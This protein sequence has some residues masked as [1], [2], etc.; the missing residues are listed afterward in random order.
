[1]ALAAS[2]S[3]TGVSLD[4]SANVG[5]FIILSITSVLLI[6]IVAPLVLFKFIVYWP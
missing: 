2:A 6:V 5:S 3:N 1:M 4:K